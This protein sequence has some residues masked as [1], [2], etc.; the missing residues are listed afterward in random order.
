VPEGVTIDFLQ[1]DV[2]GWE[3]E[4]VAST[5][6]YCYRPSIVV[7]EAIEPGTGAPSWRAWEASLFA[8]GYGFIEFDGLNRWYQNS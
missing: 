6:W 2:E 5:D 7:V 4:V 8:A 1:L 3:R